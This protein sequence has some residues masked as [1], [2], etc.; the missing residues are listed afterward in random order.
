MDRRFSPLLLL[1][2][3][4]LG[5]CQGSNGAPVKPP[6]PHVE[7]QLPVEGEVTDYADFP[8]STDAIVTVQVRARVSGYMTKVYFKDGTQVEEG[9]LLFEID[10]R[11]YKAEHDRAEGNVVQ[12]E[13]H[14]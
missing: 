5:G 11:Q 12:I 13:A 8:G 10:P 4:P 7:Y 3:A 2:L 14:L 6:P 1:L 9:N